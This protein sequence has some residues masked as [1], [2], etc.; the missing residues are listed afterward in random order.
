MTVR[1]EDLIITS[2]EKESE[3]ITLMGSYTI[4][5]GDLSE[6]QLRFY[7]EYDIKEE[8]ISELDIFLIDSKNKRLEAIADL[9][10]FSIEEILIESDMEIGE[11]K[12]DLKIANFYAAVNNKKK[13]VKSGFD[14]NIL[15]FKRKA[16]KETNNDNLA[17]FM[18][19]FQ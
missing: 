10:E 1:I 2:S 6:E 7:A 14:R 13:V 18:T 12:P 3:I 15:M 16:F 9:I 4:S 17:V 19:N 11:Y 5:V 8:L